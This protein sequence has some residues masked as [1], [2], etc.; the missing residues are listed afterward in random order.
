MS[1]TTPQAR[2]LICRRP[3]A[4]PLLVC[5]SKCDSIATSAYTN[6]GSIPRMAAIGR[7]ASQVN[8][9]VARPRGAPGEDQEG[10]DRG[11]PHIA[12]KI[13][14]AFCPPKPRLLL[15]TVRTLD[16]RA[17]FGT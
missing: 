6:C 15:R 11:A 1:D 12:R 9:R 8:R 14:D 10:G 13:T 2:G 16:A 4:S 5:G 7:S 17:A 3:R